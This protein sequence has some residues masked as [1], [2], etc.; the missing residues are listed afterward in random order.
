MNAG[1]MNKKLL[2][3]G[4][5]A[6]VIILSLGVWLS[7]RSQSPAGSPTAPTTSTS[8]RAA[9][10]KN[11]IVPNLGQKTSD[12][13]L[14]VPVAVSNAAPGVDSKYRRFELTFDRDKVTPSLIAV[15]IGD[16]VHIDL[17]ARDREY[18]FTQPD[19]GFALTLPK[20]K[21]KVLEFQAL[22]AGQFVFYCASCGGPKKGPA[23][24]LNV[25]AK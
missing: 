10:P 2:L 8:T 5:V 16:T 20:G 24:Y 12:P 21:A 6:L 14:A 18:D 22:S 23:G 4:L 25:V 15:N 3:L 13:S 19:Y 1:T 11:V 9:V 17:T 7:R